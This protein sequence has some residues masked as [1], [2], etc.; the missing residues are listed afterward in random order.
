MSAVTE[1][2]NPFANQSGPQSLIEM[3][4]IPNEV[5]EHILSFLSQRSLTTSRRFSQ[6]WKGLCEGAI[7]RKPMV[8]VVIACTGVR[9]YMKDVDSVLVANEC[10]SQS[11]LNYLTHIRVASL[12]FCAKDPDRVTPRDERQV[13]GF[14]EA[15][16]Q[17][18]GT[19][20][21]QVTINNNTCFPK[22]ILLPYLPVL[23]Y[24][25]MD[26]LNDETL[27]NLVADSPNLE[28]IQ[29]RTIDSDNL[30]SLPKGIKVLADKYMDMG[31]EYHANGS[32]LDLTKVLASPAAETIEVLS[33]V[34]IPHVMPASIEM[35]NLRKLALRLEYESENSSLVALFSSATKVEDLLIMITLRWFHDNEPAQ[36]WNRLFSKLR[37]LVHLRVEGAVSDEL[38]AAVAANCTRIKTIHCRTFNCDFRPNYLTQLV[39]LD[40][41]TSIDIVTEHL[42]G[43]LDPIRDFVTQKP[44]V[45][46]RIYAASRPMSRT[47]SGELMTTHLINTLNGRGDEYIADL[48]T[49]QRKLRLSHRHYYRDSSSSFS[50]RWNE[51]ASPQST[52]SSSSGEQN[53]YETVAMRKSWHAGSI[54]LTIRPAEAQQ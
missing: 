44:Q 23:K 20:L 6:R 7:S 49:T 13:I 16:L 35:P 33:F 10:S 34:P 27:K 1:L 19:F 36:F 53:E 14:A 2:P 25:F 52:S 28:T 31:P 22:W 8:S 47:A 50:G 30:N 5:L 18:N 29:F 54:V 3:D 21:E 42:P 51:S 38:L 43:S 17:N 15:F 9:P 37:N 32:S 4:L 11:M 12:T 45:T 40:H 41:L 39:V 48:G 46:V 24:F 26:Y